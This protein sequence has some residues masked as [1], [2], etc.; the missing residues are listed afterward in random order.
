MADFTPIETQEELNAIIAKRVKEEQERI[1]RKYEDYDAVKASNKDLTDQLAAAQKAAKDTADKYKDYD[2]KI[3]DY[4]SKIHQY[5]AASVKT[6]VALANGLPYEMA[7]RLRGETEEEIQKDAESLKT[8]W[9]PQAQPMAEAETP[10]TK[11]SERDV[12][13]QSMLSDLSGN[14]E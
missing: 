14:K 9:K 2:A 5:E 13:F 1:S 6:R 11:K 7:S 3:A 4:E 8:Y 10:V 12:A